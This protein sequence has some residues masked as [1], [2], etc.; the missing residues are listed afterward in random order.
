MMRYSN[1]FSPKTC[2]ETLIR[3]AYV[4]YSRFKILPELSIRNIGHMHI[5]SDLW[6]RIGPNWRVHYHSAADVADCI[7][8][9]SRRFPTPTSD[10][11][12]TQSSAV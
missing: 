5:L 1:G 12:V 3:A 10:G 11:A 6:P 7:S 9:L 2:E 4:I 8:D